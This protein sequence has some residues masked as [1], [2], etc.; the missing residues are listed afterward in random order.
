[1]IYIL[2]HYDLSEHIEYSSLC[3]TRPGCLSIPC[4]KVCMLIQGF[5]PIPPPSPS[6][7]ATTVLILL[8][9]QVL[10]LHSNVICTSPIHP[11][12]THPESLTTA[13]LDTVSTVLPSPECPT[14]GEWSNITCSFFRLASFI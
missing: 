9:A 10:S 1:M 6:P 12:L 2:F 4:I 13:D 14:I 8:L 7:L 11:P 3:Y 5:Q